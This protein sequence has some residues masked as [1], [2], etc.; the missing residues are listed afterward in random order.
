MNTFVDSS[1]IVALLNRDDVSYSK[2][3]NLLTKFPQ[4]RLF[5][6]KLVYYES[7]N[8][9]LRKWGKAPAK[10]I[11]KWFSNSDLNFIDITSE[12]E[13]EAV[14]LAV[15]KFTHSGPN[16]FDFVHFAC[17]KHFELDNVLTLDS[18]FSRFG[19]TVLQ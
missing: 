1:F 3:I 10:K 4:S 17:I 15:S 11:I 2:A 6:N 19:F 9:T 13:S 18:H 8:V 5:T 14:R 7:I 12:I 16:L